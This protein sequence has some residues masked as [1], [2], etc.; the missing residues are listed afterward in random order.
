MN[1]GVTFLTVMFLGF[2]G[3]ERSVL[4]WEEEVDAAGESLGLLGGEEGISGEPLASARVVGV[5]DGSNGFIAEGL[6]FSALMNAV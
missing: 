6:F 3:K 4:E 1:F 2:L 5:P